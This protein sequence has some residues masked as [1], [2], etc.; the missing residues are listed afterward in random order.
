MYIRTEWAQQEVRC[1]RRQRG[2]VDTTL[3]QKSRSGVRV[4]CGPEISLGETRPASGGD[5]LKSG[6][7][8]WPCAV[9]KPKPERRALSLL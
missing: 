9:A 5:V 1:W 8:V 3:A 2:I 6:D 7:S 4:Y